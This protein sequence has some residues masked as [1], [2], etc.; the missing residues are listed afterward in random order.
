MRDPAKAKARKQRYLKHQKVK[1][2]GP[3]A[4]GQDM[5]GRHGNHARGAA[6]GQWN[7]GR[8][9]TS[10][11]YIAV[12]VPPNHPHAWGHHPQVKYAYEHILV[13][14]EHLGRPLA[15]DELVHHGKLGKQ[16]NTV[17]NLTVTTRS[18][19]AKHHDAE[20]GRDALGRF[21]PKNL[22]IQEFPT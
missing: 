6:N 1:K 12:R 5:R 10:H 4:A 11:G 18:D 21:P 7:G 15:D 8:F 14:E 19:H 2:Y 20:R 17:E 9:I 22:R 16:V 13:M 3:D